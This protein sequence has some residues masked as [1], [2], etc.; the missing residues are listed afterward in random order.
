MP[1]DARRRTKIVRDTAMQRKPA[2][3]Q[4]WRHPREHAGGREG[5]DE[6][7]CELQNEYDAHGGERGEGARRTKMRR[8]GMGWD[9]N[10]KSTDTGNERYACG[11]M[12]RWGWREEGRGEVGTYGS[13]RE[14]YMTRW[15][16]G[17]LERLG[18]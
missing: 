6:R 12:G 14:G 4:T 5:E 1:R 7:G 18:V 13:W 15:Q 17:R 11:G 2:T 3:M 9:G 10:E 16:E 8:D